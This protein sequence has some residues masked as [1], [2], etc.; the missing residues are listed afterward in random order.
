MTR[1]MS[2]NKMHRINQRLNEMP[3]LDKSRYV[4]LDNAEV[5]LANME[6]Q[7]SEFQENMQRKLNGVRD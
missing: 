2:G 3:T 1:L 5:R 4:R 7:F 6:E